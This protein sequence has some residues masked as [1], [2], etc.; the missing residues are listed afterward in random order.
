MTDEKA[1][2]IITEFIARKIRE[3]VKDP[4]VADI[5]IPKDHGFGMKR[6]PMETKYFEVYNQPNV[7]LVDLRATPIERVTETGIKTSDKQYDLDIIVYATGF[8]AVTGAFKRIDIV[9]GSD[10]IRR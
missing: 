5:L 6:V 1:N 10:G 3:R 2:A 7:T 9:R 8:D 4:K